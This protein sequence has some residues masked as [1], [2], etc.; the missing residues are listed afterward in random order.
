M[1]SPVWHPFTQAKTADPPLKVL[2][3]NGVKLKL[4]DGRSIIDCISSWWVNIHGHGNSEIAQAIYEQAQ[5]LEHVIFAGFTH[6][7]AENL[8]RAV[9]KHLPNNLRHVF[10]S[11]N[12]TTAVETA[13]K[14]AYQYWQNIDM[15]NRSKFIAFDQG[16]H[17]ETVG[18]MSLGRTMPFFN[19][20][21]SLFFDIDLIPFPATWDSDTTYGETEQL[22]LLAVNKLL[23]NNA[24]QYAGI[25]VEPLIQGVGGMRMC[26]IEF[27]QELEKI[28]RQAGLLLIY[29]EV[30]TGFGRTGDWFACRK[31]NTQPDIIC[32]SKGLTGG[33]L[34]LALTITTDEVYQSFY[35]DDLQKA[36][37]HSHSYMG[38][39]LACA[40]ANASMKLLE[41]NSESFLE[42]EQMHRQFSKLWLAD[43]DYLEK[44]RTCGTI[45]ALDVITND[46]GH[47]FNSISLTMRQKFLELGFLMRPLGNT[48]YLMPPYCISAD[49]LESAYRAIRQVV[50]AMFASRSRVPVLSPPGRTT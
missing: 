48:I 46:T 3:G 19:R 9:L 30:M 12:G 13:M 4:E 27:M 47:Y 43:I 44:H 50:T 18:A 24:Q 35:S 29:D 45:A 6:D 32:L 16:Y 1:Q 34:P 37:F 8:A 33:F 41:R 2:S 31:T 40:A 42:M 23:S 14:M 26:R 38:N 10:F 22:A 11:D 39:P 7:P 20:F 21:K 5:V 17:G 15:P 36:F 28:I 25:I 49:E